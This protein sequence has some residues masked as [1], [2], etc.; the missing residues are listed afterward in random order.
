MNGVLHGVVS[1]RLYHQQNQ[2]RT[3]SEAVSDC[4]ALNLTLAS[5]RT[6]D[7]NSAARPDSGKVW[8]G[9]SRVWD[10]T[11][12]GPAEPVSANEEWFEQWAPDEPRDKK[13]CTA[14]RTSDG[15]WVSKDCTETLRASCYRE[16]DQ[17]HW[18]LDQSLEWKQARSQCK[19]NFAN[20]SS[21]L[22][23]NQTQDILQA[24]QT[25]DQAGEEVWIGLYLRWLWVDGSWVRWSGWD[26]DPLDSDKGCM[27]LDHSGKWDQEKCEQRFPFIC[28]QDVPE[29]KM[30]RTKVKLR[31]SSGSADLTDPKIHR[32]LL[33]QM[34][35]RL[36]MSGVSGV[37]L[38]LGECVKEPET[39]PPADPEPRCTDSVHN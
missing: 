4:T 31:L 29:V 7:Q 38:V 1:L 18:I 16:S 22:N 10:W 37:R 15:L 2:D 21:V 19:A 8:T 20:L 28:H 14:L 27:V 33:T 24:L 3:W 25:L 30:K 5:I 36:E 17:T 11:G 32:A 12:A 39:A 23:Q 9:L 13:N 34:E 26:Q 35:Q 6:S